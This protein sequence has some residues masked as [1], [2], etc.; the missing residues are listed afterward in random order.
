MLGYY[1]CRPSLASNCC[2]IVAD[3]VNMAKVHHSCA[4]GCAPTSVMPVSS[5]PVNRTAQ[6]YVQ[7]RKDIWLPMIIRRTWSPIPGDFKGALRYTA[8][9]RARE[10]MEWQQGTPLK[11]KS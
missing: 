10:P 6:R 1:D 2:A 3:V 9:R 7:A 8:F 5:A 4:E 11:N